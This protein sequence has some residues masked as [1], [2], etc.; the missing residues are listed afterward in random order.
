VNYWRL[1]VKRPLEI[2]ESFD[3][4]EFSHIHAGDESSN[5]I[6]LHTTDIPS[7][8]PLLRMRFGKPVL[9]LTEEVLPSFRGKFVKSKNWKTRLYAGQEYSIDA[10]TE[11]KIGDIS[12]QLES[13]QHIPLLAEASDNDPLERKHAIQ[14]ITQSALA[15]ISMV[16]LLFLLSYA[17]NALRP[18]KEELMVE[19]ISIQRV[20][21][22]FKKKE[23]PQ[24]EIK[25][26][27]E[28]P[29]LAQ[30]PEVEKSKKST[31]P[32]KLKKARASAAAGGKTIAAKRDVSKMGLLAI[33]SVSTS[34]DR[35]LSISKPKVISSSIQ[36]AEV[37]ASLAPL[38]AGVRAGMGTQEVASLGGLSGG[39]YKNGE[40]SN[41]IKGKSTPSIQLVRKEIEI[42]GGLDPAIIQQIIEERLAEVRYCY[43]NILLKKTNL[44]GKVSTSWTILADGSVSEMKSSSDDIKEKD[45]H[46]CVR[47]RINQWKFPSPKGGGI[48]HVKYPFVFSSLGS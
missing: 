23:E 31:S 28:E 9:R 19:K 27:E 2:E 7:V 16:V 12:F 18:K 20:E 11:W 22:L 5:Q 33:Q 8:F 35:S 48:V 40:F 44:S 38:S 26:A 45:L 43:E 10:N 39:N 42:R 3:L 46:D 34:S 13:V 1:K 37:G 17:L 25:L 29:Q 36:V 41:S 4:R 14:S 21:D 47:Q 30:A 6:C 32:R 24:P 15:H